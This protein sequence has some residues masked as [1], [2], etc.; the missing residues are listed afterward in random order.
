[1]AKS[2][3]PNT[4]KQISDLR[5]ELGQTKDILDNKIIEFDKKIIEFDTRTE[6]ING[7]RSGLKE[8]LRSNHL[9][10][11]SINA[12]YAVLGLGMLIFEIIFHNASPTNIEVG[13]AM[14]GLFMCIIFSGLTINSLGEWD[15]A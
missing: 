1:M 11:A 15:K 10:N 13:I 3:K 14:F 7:I 4:D 8:E 2:Q 6:H 12:L 9:Q 5:F